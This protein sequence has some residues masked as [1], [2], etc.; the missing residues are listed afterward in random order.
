MRHK[1]E[2]K[3]AL[4]K[5]SWEPSWAAERRT[6]AFIRGGIGQTFGARKYLWGNVPAIDVVNLASNEGRE[7]DG[8]INL[9]F[10]GE[11]LEMLSLIYCLSAH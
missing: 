3:S 8:E 4:G 6:P 7:Y 9:L 1:G 11:W 10:A 2:C 5:P